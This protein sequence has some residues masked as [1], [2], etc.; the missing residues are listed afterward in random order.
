M[1]LKIGKETGSN[2]R[3]FHM[4]NKEKPDAALHFREIRLFTETVM[5]TAKGYRFVKENN[6]TSSFSEYPFLIGMF[7]T[8]IRMRPELKEVNANR[9]KNMKKSCRCIDGIVLE[10]NDVFSFNRVVGERSEARGYLKGPVIVGGELTHSSGGGVC[11]ISTTLFN[12]ALH[13]G[14]KVLEKH[15]H[16]IDIWGDQRFIALGLDAIVVFG[17]RDLKF[18]N[19][20]PFRIAISMQVSEDERKVICKIA[21]ERETQRKIIVL[22]H[23][24]KKIPPEPINRK[25]DVNSYR[26]IN[27]WLVETKR[28]TEDAKG[29]KLTYFKRERYTPECKRIR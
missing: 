26:I 28:Y 24:I 29:K 13:S 11:Q 10:P 4:K 1:Y 22:S 27:G 19:D 7:Q 6:R 20:L 9:I 16:S 18:K 2:I 5:N 25:I 8:D 21:S 17:R 12:C 14:L 15:N 3:I 23:I